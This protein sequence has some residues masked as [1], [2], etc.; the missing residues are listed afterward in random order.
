M[1][2]K[3]LF[4]F[5]KLFLLQSVFLT[6]CTQM[7]QLNSADTTQYNS[8]TSQGIS[9]EELLSNARNNAVAN[10]QVNS[11]A[12]ST[13][14]VKRSSESTLTAK[15]QFD[16]ALEREKMRSLL[17]KAKQSKPSEDLI[18][19]YQTPYKIE[20][21][22]VQQPPVPTKESK[23]VATISINTPAQTKSTWPSSMTKKKGISLYHKQRRAE[24]DELKSFLITL[25]FQ[26]NSADIDAS[27]EEEL[28]HF[29]RLHYG[30]QFV[31]NCAISNEADSQQA[32]ET[33]LIRCLSIET[34]FK[35]RNHITMSQVLRDIEPNQVLIFS[36]GQGF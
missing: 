1:L 36:D 17:N 16:L 7:P 34:F 25:S 13:P 21:L 20:H 22:T 18:E 23:H 11:Q 2:S 24:E 35:Q 12:Q 5:K 10:P 8:D 31:I 14:E 26:T 33:A 9:I 6:A 27:L 3:K 30:E 19:P 29:S 28:D 15:E 32:H 4:S